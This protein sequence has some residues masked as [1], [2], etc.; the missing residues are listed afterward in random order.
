MFSRPRRALLH[1]A[2]GA[3][4]ALC[5]GPLARAAD[6][7]LSKELSSQEWQAIRKVISQQLAALRAGDG[8]KAFGYATPGVQAQFGDAR[9]FMAMVRHAYSP[10]LDARYSEFLEGAV[11]EG[12][13]VQ[14]LRLIAQD[15]TVLVALYTV[16]HQKRGGWRI[17]GCMIAPS[18]VQAA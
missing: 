18:T 15:N 12:I 4:I 6:P 7:P 2:A 3:A 14:P 13:V 9:S 16:E 10:L 1:G 11:I 17:S 5:L 8:G